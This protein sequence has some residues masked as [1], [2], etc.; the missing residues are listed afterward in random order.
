[1]V[2]CAKVIVI[3]LIFGKFVQNCAMNR[4]TLY[5]L[6]TIL[7]FF[8]A[9]STTKYVPE[10]SYLLNKVTIK[11]DKKTFKESELVLFLRQTPNTKMFDLISFNLGIYNLSGKNDDAWINRFIKRIGN[12]PV[13][14]DSILTIRSQTE[15]QRLYKNKG[16]ENAI[17]ESS[18][19]LKNKK[20]NV[21]YHIKANEPYLINDIEYQFNDSIIK[22][23]IVQDSVNSLIKRGNLFDVDMLENERI[24]ITGLL[25]N[26]GYYY[27]NKE[28][29]RFLAD[30]T[31]N[32]NKVDLV[33]RIRR[34]ERTGERNTVVRSA[35]QT[36]SIHSITYVLVDNVLN[37]NEYNNQENP[38]DTLYINNKRVIYNNLFINP[39]ILDDNTFITIGDKY[40]EGDVEE[41]Y[42]RINGLHI[43]Q[44]LRLDFAETPTENDSIKM[45]DCTILLTPSK[46]QSFT[47]EAEGTNSEGDF[48]IAGKFGYT[49]RNI[50]KGGEKFGLQ[51]RASNEAIGSIRNIL[52]YSAWEV[53]GE[54]SLEFPRFMF[55]FVNKNFQRNNK[56]TTEFNLNYSYQTRPDFDRTI[57]GIGLKYKWDSYL[58]R[59]AYHTLD[60]LDLS[61][62]YLPP[63]SISDEFRDNYLNSGSLL[64]YSYEDHLI[65]RTAYTISYSSRAL[66]L[67]RNG[68]SVKGG[69]E[70]AGN[71]LY[72]ISSLLQTPQQD[73]SYMI[74]KI[75][76]SQYFKLDGE[77]S[78]TQF[79]DASNRIV[80]HTAMG[81][82]VP[83]GNS[84]ILPFE[85]R[86]Y[87][88]GSNS[89]RAWQ[90]RTLGP[91]SYNNS[92]V[93]DYMSQ[94][95]DMR[96]DFNIEYRTKLVWVMELG[97]FIDAGNVW[98]LLPYGDQV[99]GNFDIRNAYKEIALGYGLGLRFDF[100]FFLL[101]LDW[102]IK[103]YDPSK[104][105]SDAWRFNN[106]WD[107]MKDT[108]L[109]FAVGYPF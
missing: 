73:G 66:Q 92:G 41:T 55:P 77:Y 7:I 24:R 107:V 68:Y 71:S 49:H 22:K 30:S 28:Y 11:T 23:L 93:I 101:R 48:G 86:Y 15:L 108:A 14:Y 63:Y 98:T 35:H 12:P 61:Y 90:V 21:T 72:A 103:A 74:G 31:E 105:G 85:K 83:Y 57:A 79:L 10:G 44:F 64:K 96:V 52:S 29:I 84:S 91:G 17:V 27:F 100:S 4:F 62:V 106:S 81:I 54:T 94:S 80:Y 65:L 109:H 42:R 69:V 59:N 1:M 95:G 99:G 97:A 87:G 8:T 76:F 2:V 88:G 82:G 104:I 51:L 58:K 38:R 33:L 46:N 39:V 75:K 32:E 26:N 56:A 20:A 16:Y 67:N 47:I 9:C 102:G 43:T 60:F 36:Y 25:R 53:G 89:L 18:V 40:T 37:V 70:L 50:L 34:M 6:F 13:I 5:T 3:I 19:K 78:Y 45:L